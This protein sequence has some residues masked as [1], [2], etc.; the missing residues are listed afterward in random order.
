M[1]DRKVA[2]Y[3]GLFSRFSAQRKHR[4]QDSKLASLCQC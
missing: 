4:V 1:N 2:R 3:R